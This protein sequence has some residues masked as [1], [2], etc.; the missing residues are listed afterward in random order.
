[1]IDQNSIIARHRLA[2]DL[3]D[4]FAGHD[5]RRILC[6]LDDELA[7]VDVMIR[8]CDPRNDGRL[9]ALARWRDRV[10]S[11]RTGLDPLADVVASAAKRPPSAHYSGPT[12]A[13]VAKRR[14]NPVEWMVVHGVITD[15]EERAAQQIAYVYEGITARVWT[16]MPQYSSGGGSPSADSYAPP[17]EV[18]RL[19]RDAWVPW[20]AWMRAPSSRIGVR[21][22]PN[23]DAVIDVVVFGEPL[24]DVR[25]SHRVSYDTLVRMLPVC[26]SR[27]V[28]IAKRA[29]V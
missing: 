9:R 4:P 1:M 22:R 21:I 5:A 11:R 8:Q 29:S 14:C 28:E 26:L 2:L 17:E 18:C 12:A 23:L 24:D 19:Y 7:R 27:Y 25:R 20:A 13:T 15:D 16:T 6:D 10:A 3:R